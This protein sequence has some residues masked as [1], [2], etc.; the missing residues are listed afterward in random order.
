MSDPVRE[1]LERLKRTTADMREAYLLVE[2]LAKA[3]SVLLEKED[4]LVELCS[5]YFIRFWGRVEFF[6]GLCRK[7]INPLGEEK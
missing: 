1:L 7:R 3:D 6:V 2:R 5:C 4:V